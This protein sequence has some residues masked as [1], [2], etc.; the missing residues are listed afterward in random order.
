M[1]RKRVKEMTEKKGHFE[2]GRW[3]EENEPAVTALPGTVID[4]RLTDATK[5]I[6]SSIDDMISVTHDLVTTE[7]GKQYIEKTMKETHRHV[8]KSFDD[9]LS[10][11]KTELDKAKKPGK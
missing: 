8:Q 6:L 2:Q 7:E 3:V 4:K 5:S 1:D 10:R 9:I 11:V